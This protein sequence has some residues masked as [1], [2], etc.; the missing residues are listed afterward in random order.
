VH[1]Y[2]QRSMSVRMAACTR[3]VRQAHPVMCVI[4]M[5]QGSFRPGRLL[6]AGCRAV[7][8]RVISVHAAQCE[9]FGAQGAETDRRVIGAGG[10]D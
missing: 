7:C 3:W 1:D 5:M 8:S 4:N 10:S 9:R 2:C 6:F